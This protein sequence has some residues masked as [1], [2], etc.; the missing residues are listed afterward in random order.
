MAIARVAV[1]V[2]QGGHAV[3]E[4]VIRRRFDSGLRNFHTMY[5][6]MVHAWMYYDNSQELPLLIESADNE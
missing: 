6:P 1:R 3:P 5:K 4:A 2:S